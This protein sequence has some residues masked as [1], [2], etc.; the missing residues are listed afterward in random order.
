MR[1]SA[2]LTQKRHWGI[3]LCFCAG[4]LI[5]PLKTAAKPQQAG[6]SPGIA[7]AEQAYR[8]V[9]A[10]DYAGAV[11]NFRTALAADPSNLRWRND[12]AYACLSA[13]ALGDAAAEFE[14][15]YSADPDDFGVALQ[16]GYIF[17]QL[18]REGDAKKYFEIVARGADDALA[19]QARMA[20]VNL[21]ASYVRER[22]QKA[23][24]LLAQK[25]TSEAIGTFESVHGDDP[26]D[27]SVALQLG[28]LYA[29]AGRA[30]KAR[31]LF[32]AASANPDPKIAAQ[33]QAGLDEV[34]RDTKPWFA[35][36]YAAPFYQSRFS[37]EINPANAK[38]GLNVSRYFQP[39]FGV[40]FSRDIRSRAGTLPEI[41]SDNSSVFSIGIQ[42]VLAN[43]GAVFYAE[44]G[45]ALNLVGTRPR[46]ASDY[47]AGAYW[48]RSWGGGLIPP[49]SASHSMA[50]IGSLYADA[51][52]YSRYAHNVIGSVQFREGLR[53]PTGRALP[54]ALLGAVNL[55]KD[56]NGNFYNNIVE[57]GPALRVSPVR[58]M[59]S[60]SLEIQYLRG[61]YTIHDPGN[62]YEPR[63]GD[64][65]VFLIWSKNF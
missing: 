65:R 39:Y 9:A 49:A 18:H 31:Q 36:F 62:P 34:R 60:L 25:R 5:A 56:S 1:H 21:R 57:T 28:Y 52:F 10:K 53:L 27:A 23:Y 45:T 40:R 7:A 32:T 37:N 6:A 54:I 64:F 11:R 50:W 26:S 47:R 41:Y 46:A 58:Q 15:S 63:Y 44:A 29:A 55:V 12:L 20:L 42:S 14:R 3:A 13:G 4:V 24:D 8:E 2:M 48:S 30:D 17:Q 16:L 19:G 59:P 43:T 22:K 35:S 51:G 61:F 38:I 33:A